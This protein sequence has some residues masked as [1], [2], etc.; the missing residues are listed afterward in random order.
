MQENNFEP[1]AALLGEGAA[2]YTPHRAPPEA[3]FGLWEVHPNK[4]PVKDNGCISLIWNGEFLSI[5]EVDGEPYQLASCGINAEF[6]ARECAERICALNNGDKPTRV[7]DHLGRE[8]V[9]RHT[10]AS[11]EAELGKAA[12]SAE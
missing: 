3:G 8:H 6:T 5:G 4:T 9:S 1:L 12:L 11:V 2:Q 10:A 7:I